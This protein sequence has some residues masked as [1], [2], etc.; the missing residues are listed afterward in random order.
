MTCRRGGPLTSQ[1]SSVMFYFHFCVSPAPTCL[2]PTTLSV[3]FPFRLST[4][5]LARKGKQPERKITILR[6]GREM[7]TRAVSDVASS[8]PVS[9][10]TTTSPQDNK[11]APA[12]ISF[13]GKKEP[14][15]SGSERKI[16]ILAPPGKLGTVFNMSPEGGAVHVSDI[17]EDSPLRGELRLGD[18]VIAVDDQDVSRMKAVEISSEHLLT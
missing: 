8:L 7:P 5:L 15:Q 16:E 4:V 18:K 6:D 13:Q 1:V 10:P 9:T 12:L 2:I 3:L 17:K 14:P 11:V